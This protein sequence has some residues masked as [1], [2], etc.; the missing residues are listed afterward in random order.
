MVVIIISNAVHDQIWMRE[1]FHECISN[2]LGKF[3]DV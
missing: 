2:Y 1:V 3:A